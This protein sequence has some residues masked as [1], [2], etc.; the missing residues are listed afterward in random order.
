MHPITSKI[1]TCLPG[2]VVLEKEAF[3]ELTLTVSRKNLHAVLQLLHDDPV[4]NFDHITDVTSVDFPNEEP[5]FA[6]IY[7]LYSIE[8]NH[9][10]RVKARVPEDDCSVD[11][12]TDIWQGANFLEREVYD[13]MGI[14]FNNHP[15][16][17]RILMTEDYN[18][19]YPLRKDFPVEGR[20]WRDSFEFFKESKA[21]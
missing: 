2:S 20:G 5:R 21:S 1:E 8:K 4:L 13:M 19:G 14:T 18:E 17:R 3:G 10:V 12:A 6:V 11:S 9:R 16:L 15:D 7:Q